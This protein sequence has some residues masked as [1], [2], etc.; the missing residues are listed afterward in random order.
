MAT[1]R[2]CT[3]GALPAAAVA[4]EALRRSN[5]VRIEDVRQNSANRR[6]PPY[7]CGHRMAV[8][9]EHNNQQR[10]GIFLIAVPRVDRRLTVQ[11]LQESERPRANSLAHPLGRTSKLRYVETHL[12]RAKN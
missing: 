3:G 10:F 2:R 11:L 5:P 6:R 4:G 12:R 9:A 7:V 8:Y 1:L